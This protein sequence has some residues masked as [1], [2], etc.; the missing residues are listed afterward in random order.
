MN[1]GVER[2]REVRAREKNNGTCRSE[3]GG[4]EDGEIELLTWGIRC[5]RTEKK[6]KGSRYYLNDN[7]D[8]V[9]V[10]RL[11]RIPDTSTWLNCDIRTKKLEKVS[12]EDCRAIGSFDI[13]RKRRTEKEET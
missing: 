2:E 9:R 6:E 8:S 5:A 4:R 11:T 7:S 10:G 3:R 13:I 12:L 1:A